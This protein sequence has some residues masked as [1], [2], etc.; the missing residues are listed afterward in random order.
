MPR[1]YKNIEI[2]HDDI[3]YRINWIIYKTSLPLHKLDIYMKGEQDMAAMTLEAE[4]NELIR[5]ILDVNDID[6]LE[7]IKKLLYQEEKNIDIVAEER[8]PYRTKAE[9]LADFDEACKEMKQAQEGKLEGKPLEDL[10]NEL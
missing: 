2:V 8:V 5:R 1:R 9:I 7:K 3:P 10:L 6:I 4:K